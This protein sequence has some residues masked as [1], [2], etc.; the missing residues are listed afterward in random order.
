MQRDSF[1]VVLPKL[2]V[3]SR[4]IVV[5]FTQRQEIFL[6]FRIVS[7]G[8]VAHPSS[9]SVGGGVRQPGRE[10]HHSVVSSLEVKSELLCTSTQ[11]KKH[12]CGLRMDSLIFMVAA[13]IESYAV[14]Y[15]GNVTE[16]CLHCRMLLS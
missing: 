4:E 8:F 13:E 9:I 12:L 7:F 10:A 3:D 16:A 2:G 1:T 11:R 5:P 15:K 14:Y 6:F